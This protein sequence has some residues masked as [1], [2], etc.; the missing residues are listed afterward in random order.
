MEHGYANSLRNNGSSGANMDPSR[1]PQRA[2]KWCIERG[3]NAR[4]T[5]E[6]Y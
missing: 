6:K 4:K 3:H 1:A 2:H 5:A